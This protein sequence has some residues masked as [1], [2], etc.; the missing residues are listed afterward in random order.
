MNNEMNV[1]K[2]NNTD[3]YNGR[4]KRYTLQKILHKKKMRS[5][6]FVSNAKADAMAG[7]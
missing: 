4:E 1:M 2:E 5:S 7:R 3:A 6:V